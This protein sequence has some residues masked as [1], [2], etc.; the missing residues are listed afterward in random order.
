[1]GKHTMYHSGITMVKSEAESTLKKNT[2]N[3]PLVT[4]FPLMSFMKLSYRFA[5]ESV[6]TTEYFPVLHYP[7]ESALKR[8]NQRSLSYSIVRTSL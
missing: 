1:M 4:G 8:W 6:C 2:L 7:P 3:K 5:Y